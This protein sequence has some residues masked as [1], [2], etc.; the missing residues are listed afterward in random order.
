M[1]FKH[2]GSDFFK[3]VAGWPTNHCGNNILNLEIIYL[4]GNEH[5]GKNISKLGQQH[6]VSILSRCFWWLGRHNNNVKVTIS[7]C[8][9]PN[10]NLRGSAKSTSHQTLI[11]FLDSSPKRKKL[12]PFWDIY[13]WCTKLWSGVKVGF[14]MAARSIE[15]LH[16]RN[17]V[18]LK[19]YKQA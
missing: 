18:Q 8:S 9:Q 10:H 13:F 15:V 4:I 17:L 14:E 16:H 19:S 2:I 5:R 6:L 11:A 12:V 7:R 1:F 3:A